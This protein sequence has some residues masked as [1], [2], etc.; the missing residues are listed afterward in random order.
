MAVTTL[1]D[2]PAEPAPD[3]IF[4]PDPRTVPVVLLARHRPRPPLR[5][6]ARTSVLRSRPRPGAADRHHLDQGRR[7]QRPISVLLHRRRRRWQAGRPGRPT[8]ADRGGPA[9]PQGSD[10][11]DP[12]PRRHADE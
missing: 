10:A 9:A 1:P 3:D 12:R 4:S 2:A 8:P 6:E 5:T 7:A 11:A